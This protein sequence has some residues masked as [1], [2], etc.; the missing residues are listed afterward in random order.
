MPEEEMMMTA[1]DLLDIENPIDAKARQWLVRIQTNFWQ[2]DAAVRTR[3]T[4]FNDQHYNPLKVYEGILDHYKAIKSD[5]DAFRKYLDD[6][7]FPPEST[8]YQYYNAYVLYYSAY[9]D[10]AKPPALIQEELDKG[11][12]VGICTKVDDGDTIF[13]NDK[14]IRLAG[15]DSSEKG[16]YSGAGPATARMTDLVLGKLVTVYFDPHTP[17]EMYRRVL[18]AVYL[19]D[20]NR[21]DLYK[22]VDWKN[23][24]VNYIMVKECLSCPNNKGRNMYI[25]HDEIKAAYEDCKAADLPTMARLE[26]K[27]KPTHAM[28]FVNGQDTHRITPDHWDVVPGTYEITIVADG[29]SAHHETVEINRGKHEIYRVLSPI[30]TATGVINIFT[31]PTDCDILINDVAQGVAPIIGLKEL[32]GEILAITAVKTGYNSRTELISPIAGRVMTVTLSLE[33][34]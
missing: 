4:W 11:K 10:V 17:M 12:I 21:E 29:C 19:G 30:P 34:I 16:T 13:V 32:A 5:L 1:T 33:K 23:I 26:I 28:I 25:D 14:E 6:N 27:S 15:V 9:T 18:G 24:F 2:F 31:E 7:N 22:R 3:V 20:G 8:Y